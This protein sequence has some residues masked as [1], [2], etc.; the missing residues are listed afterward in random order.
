MNNDA[1]RKIEQLIA[2]VRQQGWQVDE[3]RRHFFIKPPK[4]YGLITVSRTPS[5]PRTFLNSR[6]DVNRVLRQ[7]GRPE[8]LK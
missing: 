7:M 2:A 3:D 8:V 5:D 1:K 6:A 4:P